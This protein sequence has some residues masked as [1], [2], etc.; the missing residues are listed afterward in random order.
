MRKRFSLK[1]E[2]CPRLIF[3]CLIFEFFVL[4]AISRI[5]TQPFGY[6]LMVRFKKCLIDTSNFSGLDLKNG[7]FHECVIRDTYFK[8]SNLTGAD[9]TKS[10]L[11]RSIFHNT[12]LSKSNFRGAMNYSINPLTNTLSKARFSKPE[13]LSLLDH[14]DIVMD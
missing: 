10:D 13:V 11:A 4:Q 5:S 3:K 8:E 2:P 6:F 9:F 12:N 7:M 14:M 1:L